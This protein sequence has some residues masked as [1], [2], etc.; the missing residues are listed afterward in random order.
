MEISNIIIGEVSRIL[1]VGQD[2]VNARRKICIHCDLYKHENDS[3]NHCGCPIDRKG[4]AE[5]S[6]CPIKKW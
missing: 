5:K 6:H 3:C 4:R 1:N 2:L